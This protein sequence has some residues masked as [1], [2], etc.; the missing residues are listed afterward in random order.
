MCEVEEGYRMVT[1]FACRRSNCTATLYRWA[2]LN[3][4]GIWVQHG[5]N[6]E[7]R[8][9]FTHFEISNGRLE[10]VEEWLGDLHK[11]LSSEVTND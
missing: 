2:N 7:A 5:E 8:R 11:Y 10:P 4:H 9:L 6:K 1:P 3:Q